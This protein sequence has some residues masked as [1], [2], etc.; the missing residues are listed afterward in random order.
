M[1]KQQSAVERALELRADL[2]SARQ[3]AA[4]AD[5]RVSDAQKT[6]AQVEQELR[7]AGIDSDKDLDA[8]I[9]ALVDEARKK[10]TK[11]QTSLDRVSHVLRGAES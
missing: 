2:D 8:Q 1:P 11:I 4:A 3:A 9:D 10:L 6:M 7:D 5:A